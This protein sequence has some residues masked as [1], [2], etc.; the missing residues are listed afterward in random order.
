M[1]PPNASGRDQRGAPVVASYA[2]S[3]N[4]RPG[5]TAAQSTASVAVYSQ[6]LASAGAAELGSP[7]AGTFQ[8]GEP[9]A[10]SSAYT[11]GCP[12]PVAHSSGRLSFATYPTPSCAAP[13][14]TRPGPTAVGPAR[15]SSDPVA[16]SSATAPAGCVAPSTAAGV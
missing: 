3:P 10:R 4:L 9:S 5:G 12:L 16:G 8:S 1:A 7:A 2:A 11:R 15:H 6:P 14:T 13:A